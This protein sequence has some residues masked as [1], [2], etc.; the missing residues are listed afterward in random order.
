MRHTIQPFLAAVV[1]AGTL[2]LPPARSADAQG[3][4]PALLVGPGR[5]DW[6][7]RYTEG[8][9][10]SNLAVAV[11]WDV[12]PRVTLRAE[13]GRASRGVDM[14]PIP[15]V[16]D[17]QGRLHFTQTYVAVLSRIA[18]VSRPERWHAYVE[19]GAAGHGGAS[20]DVDLEGGLLGGETLG[21]DDWAPPPGH[22]V[23][24]AQSSGVRPVLGLG[25]SRRWFGAT[26]RLEPMG[27]LA[28]TANGSISAT[29]VTLN[30]ELTYRRRK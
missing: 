22:P 12:K 8:D 15:G 9:E 27:A 20:C 14:G 23:I 5:S 13:L 10:S 18:I 16:F 30:L 29:T 21:C 26:L 2:G 11:N 19:A 7:G 6:S 1:A 4:H 3:V 25:A 24:T 17:K 28:K